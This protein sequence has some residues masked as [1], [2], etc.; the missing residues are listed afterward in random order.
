[1]TL[2]GERIVLVYRGKYSTML[3]ARPA[4]G[5]EVT[6]F[7]GNY[8]DQVDLVPDGAGTSGPATMTVVLVSETWSGATTPDLDL[9][10]EVEW[11]QLEKPIEQ[12]PRYQSGGGAELDSDDLDAIEEWRNAT[13]AEDRSTLYGA[14]T[15]NAKELADKIRRGQSSY[16]VPAPVVRKT[17]KSFETPSSSAQGIRTTS[18][19]VTGAPS[20][21]VWLGTA[22]RAVRQGGRGKWERVQE[23][24]GADEWDSDLY[25]SS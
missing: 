7:E 10:E 8:V 23:W 4:I 14:L 25:P 3:A 16:I 21:Y 17:T 13:T 6:G 11:S 15:T 18:A 24:T 1:L 2:E 19:P 22:D 12:H 20:G 5:D 9:T